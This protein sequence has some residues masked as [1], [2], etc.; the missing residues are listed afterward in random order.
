M[1]TKKEQT[2]E[3]LKEHYP[4]IYTIGQERLRTCIKNRNNKGGLDEFIW[5]STEEGHE[6]WR[7]IYRHGNFDEFEK[8][9]GNPY[10]DDIINSQ[11]SQPSQSNNFFSLLNL[12]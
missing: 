4:K 10:D 9:Y 11:S 8:R 6:F 12:I 5:A 1:K 7:D 2:W 3:Y